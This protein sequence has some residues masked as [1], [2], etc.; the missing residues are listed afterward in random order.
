MKAEQYPY[1]LT[2]AGYGHYTYLIQ[3]RGKEYKTTTNNTH[4]TDDMRSE[5]GQRDGREL[6]QLRGA[7]A[8]R[9]EAIRKHNLK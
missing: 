7:K 8:L 9:M 1:S 6:R 4:A 2:L 3:Y 5:E